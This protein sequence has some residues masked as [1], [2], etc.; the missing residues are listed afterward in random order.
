MKTHKVL[1]IGG[2]FGGVKAAQILGRD[3]RCS[4]KMI[5]PRNFMEYH[6]A[7][8]R[9]TTGRSPLEVCVP[10]TQLL[11]SSNAE[12]VKDAIVEIDHANKLAKGT[13][14]STYAYDTAI[15]AVGCESSYFGIQGVEQNAFSINSVNDALKLRRHIHSLF[16]RAKDC[17]PAEKVPLLHIVVI[18]G[19]ASGTELAGEFGAYTRN[20]ARIHN[21]DPSLVTVD[22]IEAMPR[23]LPGLPEALSAHALKRLRK[24]GVNVYLNRSVVKEDVDSLFLKDMEMTTKTVVWTAGLQAN[25]MTASIAGAK[26]DRRGRVTVDDRLQATGMKDFY[27]IGDVASTQYSGM[28]QTALADAEYVARS[29]QNQLSGWVTEPYIQPKPSYAV[30]VGPSY[31][32]VLFNGWQFH[33]FVGWM[34][35][36]AADFI[37]FTEL[38]GPVRAVKAW[39]AGTVKQESCPTCEK[40]LC[41][42]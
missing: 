35:R 40:S 3:S 9:L 38:L 18:G 31:A 8:Y 13:S 4:V 12:V 2:G 6:A 28:A 7:T 1:I 27:A 41:G 34:L 30:P 5:D 23:I 29:L 19:G 37:A 25:R 17:E 36:R 20:L 33:G 39:L 42:C 16:D 32:V 15:L 10:Y 26:L 21:V 14:G 11:R 24:L 22:L